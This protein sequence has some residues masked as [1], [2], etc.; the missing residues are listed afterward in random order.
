[1]SEE[2]CHAALEARPTDRAAFLMACSRISGGVGG[3]VTDADRI[4][5]GVVMTLS[6]P[7]L[8]DRERERPPRGGRAAPAADRGQP[9]EVVCEGL[10]HRRRQKPGLSNTRSRDYVNRIVVT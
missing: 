10:T 1:M 8:R 4:M 9:V 2:I 3:I 6:L 7:L 5:P